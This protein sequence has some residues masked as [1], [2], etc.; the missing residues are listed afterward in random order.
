MLDYFRFHFFFVGF[1][2]RVEE[3][4]II[5]GFWLRDKWKEVKFNDWQ[6]AIKFSKRATGA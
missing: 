3:D 1:A 2:C 4:K 6:S 5:L